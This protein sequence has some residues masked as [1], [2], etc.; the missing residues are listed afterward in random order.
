MSESPMINEDLL[1]R[2]YLPRDLIDVGRIYASLNRESRLISYAG[3]YVCCFMGLPVGIIVPHIAGKYLHVKELCTLRR[4]HRQGVATT[5]IN[6]VTQRAVEF[7]QIK[8]V[9]AKVPLDREHSDAIAFFKKRY[10]FVQSVDDKL[11]FVDRLSKK[12]EVS[13]W[14]C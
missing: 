4:F 3:S 9:V 10:E 6:Y 5:L 7:S 12:K 13:T 14:S 11:L 8:S 1:V 2:T